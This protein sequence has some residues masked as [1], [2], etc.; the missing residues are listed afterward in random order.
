VFILKKKIE[1]KLFDPGSNPDSR[2]RNIT[3]D[4]FSSVVFYASKI[5]S[6]KIGFFGKEF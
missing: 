2:S 3:E 4:E 6:H 1:E 5:R